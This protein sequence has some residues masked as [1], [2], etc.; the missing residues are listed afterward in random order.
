MF[1]ITTTMKQPFLLLTTLLFIVSSCKQGD[2]H[3]TMIL[4]SALESGNQRLLRQNEQLY[5]F[6]EKAM[7]MDEKSV[8]PWYDKA[9]MVKKMSGEMSGFLGSAKN[10]ITS[11]KSSAGDVRTELELRLGKFY[12]N[13]QGFVPQ[14]DPG[15]LNKN[16]PDNDLSDLSVPLLTKIQNDVASF[17]NDLLNLYTK[18]I[19][20][21]P[22]NFKFDKI[23][24]IVVPRSTAVPVGKQYEASIFFAATYSTA[25]PEIVMDGAENKNVQVNNGVGNY[26]ISTSAPGHYEY[27]GVMKVK[28][29]DGKTRDYP[30]KAGYDVVK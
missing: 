20:D 6:L 26:S 1:L 27:S 8:R 4:N 29:P 23:Q 5:L 19:S 13:M 25:N 10:D 30:F 12:T 11:G 2:D 9:M 16:H 18:K 22:N 14:E 3:T 28:N 24:V 21:K 15:L 17:E 7:T